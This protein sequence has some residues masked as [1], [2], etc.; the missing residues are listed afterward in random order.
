[1]G[2]FVRPVLRECFYFLVQLQVNRMLYNYGKRYCFVHALFHGRQLYV[3]VGFKH[4][5]YILFSVMAELSSYAWSKLS[6]FQGTF[7]SK[8]SRSPSS[9]THKRM[10][11]FDSNVSSSGQLFTKIATCNGQLL[12]VKFINKSYVAITQ[13]L[14]K[15]INEVGSMLAVRISKNVLHSIQC[16]NTC[17]KNEERQLVNNQIHYLLL[18]IRLWWCVFVR[19]SCSSLFRVIY[20]VNNYIISYIYQVYLYQL[21]LVATWL[22]GVHVL[23]LC[24]L[25]A[26][27]PSAGFIL[28]D[29]AL[30]SQKREP[31]DRSMCGSNED[32][33]ANPI[34]S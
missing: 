34:L 29:P 14:I 25:V 33:L 12:A 17:V 11:S 23:Y 24:L 7:W 21:W 3:S 32:L 19:L 9:S 6:L 4:I 15:E 20:H 18:I 1:M 5:A 10:N 27:L 13:S 28:L 8:R 16:T 31:I 22:P 26:V 30:E 2:G